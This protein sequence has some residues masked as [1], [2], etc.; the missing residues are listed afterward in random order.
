M[1]SSVKK[2][3][4]GA[5]VV[6]LALQHALH[7]WDGLL[8][9][10]PIAVYAC[11][12]DGRLTQYNRR[13]SDIWGSSPATGELGPRFCGAWKAWDA[14]GASLPPEASPVAEALRT[15][16]PLGDREMMIEQPDG[17]RITV[18]ASVEPLFDHAGQLVGALACLQDITDV[19]RATEELAAQERWSRELLDAL[20]AALYTTD[21]EGRITFYNRAAAELAGTR[22]T[23][24][25]DRW[26]V[27]WKL[28]TPDGK[29]LPHEE[30]PMAVALATGEAVRGVEAIAERP[31]GV[32]T[33]FMPY[34]TPIRDETGKV[35]GAVNMLV[36]IS[37]QKHSEQQQK[38]LID[39]LNH[40]VKNT[41]T[42]VQSI[43]RQ[44]AR[45]AP[46]LEAFNAKFEARLMALSSAHEFLSK[47]KWEGVSLHDI[48]ARELGSLA[49]GDPERVRLDGPL[50]T[51]TPRAALALSM[52]FHELGTNAERHGA[53]SQP[54]GRVQV[55]WKLRRAGADPAALVLTWRELDGPSVAAP[56]HTGFGARMVER[57]IEGELE[58]QCDVRFLRKGVRCDI[59][60]PLTLAV[61]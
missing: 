5:Q 22:P 59:T 23:L 20:P 31:D 38:L 37:P 33:P 56:E 61:R 49:A 43:A 58:G 26:C 45:G 44:T 57:T 8:N 17:R 54:G 9:R 36:D 51:L 48:L 35:V 18:L 50:L 24:G 42:T 41:L 28:Y 7:S 11:D 52:V 13:A 14:D 29:R 3:D 10:L 53:L 47:R 4:G 27:T 30:C 21:A 39:E 32:R 16:Q 34:P 55:S 40:R 15:G 2:V 25:S 6:S 60:M 12:S 1:P 46:S 19:K